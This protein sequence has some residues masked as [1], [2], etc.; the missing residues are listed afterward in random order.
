MSENYSPQA[1]PA[2]PPTVAHTVELAFN[3]TEAVYVCWILQQVLPEGAAPT[4]RH[5][6]T[7]SNLQ[8]GFDA[9]VDERHDEIDRQEMLNWLQYLAGWYEH[10]LDKCQ[11]RGGHEIAREM[12]SIWQAFAQ[13]DDQQARG[14]TVLEALGIA[15]IRG[16]GVHVVE[17]DLENVSTG[18]QSTLRSL[19]SAFGSL[20]SKILV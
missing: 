7:C 20:G 4:A 8:D 11:P 14:L 6:L 15:G 5:G 10:L 2:S 16:L 12:Q 13:L 9:L 19:C 3:A 17:S 18:G 1:D